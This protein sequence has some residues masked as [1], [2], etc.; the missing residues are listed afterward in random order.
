[1]EN[2]YKYFNRD[3]SWLSFNYRVLLEATDQTWPVYERI[4]FLAIHASN[5]EEFYKIRVA[6]HQDVIMK[7]KRAEEDSENSELILS[8]IKTEVTRQQKEF[9]CIFKQLIIPELQNNKIYLYQNEQVN[10]FHKDFIRNYFN[11]EIFPFLEPV[12]ILKDEI[13]YF[14]RDNRIYLVIRLIRNETKDFYYAIMK[15][16]FAK[17]PRFVKLPVHDNNYYF[18]FVEDIVKANLRT[19][20]PGF[21]IDCSHC[22]KISRDADIYIDEEETSDDNLVETIKQKIKR[23]KIGDLSRFSYDYNMPE[24]F[25]AFV[26]EAFTIPTGDMVPDSPHL[27]MQD[28]IKLPNPA[29]EKLVSKPHDPIKIPML[30]NSKKISSVVQKQDIFLFYPYHSFDYFIRFLEEAASTNTK[31]ESIKITQY[32]V[33]ERSD[34]INTLIHAAQNGK[35]VTVFV[36]LKARFDEENNL[37]TA[38]RMERAGIKIIYSLPGLKVH[39]K[40][41][42][43]TE[44][45]GLAGSQT[46]RYAY[47]STGNFNEK[48]AKL[49]SDMS[50]LTCNKQLTNEVDRV[51]NILE[52]TLTEYKF[53]HLLVAR[54]NLLPNLRQLIHREIKQAKQGQKARIILK[55]NGLQDHSMIDELY[56][57]SEAGVEIDLI[58]RGICC[59]VP[60][61]S[62]SKNIRITRLVD[63]Y[64]EHARIWYFYNNGKED[65]F[66]T[67]TDWMKRNLYRRI[68]IAFPVINQAIKRKV[69]EILDIQLK[70]NV[71]GCFIDEHLNNVFKTGI[72]S[73]PIRAQEKIYTIL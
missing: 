56:A 50:I 48:T 62:Y 11:E 2:Q 54:F 73:E 39:A 72:G 71:K 59:L 18:V 28:L 52:G 29:G 32:R 58:V 24:D 37:E 6:E 45:C 20:F 23:R 30:D 19:V 53:K 70:D 66:L 22:V 25:L 5:L 46:R 38:E 68:E 42:L 51:F 47:L 41:A 36:E 21:T 33:A 3:I 49:Y 17:A 57:A 69:I 12:L 61:Q 10:D 15:I 8:E 26:S 60:N 14:I 35:K 43:I 65:L 34:V 44:K 31:V 55:M 63:A 9:S 13:R 1:M 7:K 4:N 40:V 16:P 64:L 67:S 27:N